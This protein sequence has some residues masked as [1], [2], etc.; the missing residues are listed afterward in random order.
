MGH[1]RVERSGGTEVDLKEYVDGV[2]LVYT[3][4]SKNKEMPGRLGGEQGQEDRVCL[5]AL[6]NKQ[7]KLNT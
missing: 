6:G 3:D 1:S 7:S 4:L 5:L 2:S